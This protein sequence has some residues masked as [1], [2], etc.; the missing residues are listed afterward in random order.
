MSGSTPEPLGDDS[1][2]DRSTHGESRQNSPESKG[3]AQPDEDG[4]EHDP[5]TD[6]AENSLPFLGTGVEDQDDESIGS[7]ENGSAKSSRPST[8]VALP[9]R[10]L[11]L[12]RRTGWS[13][14]DDYE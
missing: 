3:R 4:N 12:S 14:Y 5:S 11:G 6:R 1:D 13:D 8:P 2:N 9:V 7:W 10:P